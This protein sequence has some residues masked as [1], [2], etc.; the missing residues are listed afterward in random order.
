MADLTQLPEPDRIPGV[1]HPRETAQVFG[2]AQAEARFLA[3]FNS[4]RLHHAWLI[5]GPE[6]IGKATLAWRIARFLLAAPEAEGGLFGDPAPA[7]TLDIPADHPVQ[8]RTRALSE[9]RLSLLRRGPTEK[10][11]RLMTQI[12][13]DEVRRM[14]EHFALSAAEPGRRV[15]IIDSADELNTASANALLKLLEE[16]PPGVTFLIVAHRPS[17]LLP[18][19][20]SRCRDLPLQPL[21]PADLTRA[22]AAA[23][24]DGTITPA[25]AELAAGSVGGAILLDA[26]EGTATYAALVDLFATLPRLDRARAAALAD[27]AGGRAAEAFADQLLD[28]MLDLIARLARAGT[29]GPPATE[30]APGEAQVMQRLA[31]GPWAGRLWAD[32]H[33]TLAPRVRH[34]RAVNLDPGTLFLDMVQKSHD[35]ATRVAQG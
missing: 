12:A 24:L 5:A 17:G 27:R 25:L 8:R 28:R 16:P 10:G 34:G 33:G 15:A 19:I 22:A 2:H 30:A 1:P 14:K 21:A 11:D 7:T 13:V 9:P 35:T 29:A 32:L 18:T 6:G 20:R 26:A 31:P 3:A 23:G 4:G